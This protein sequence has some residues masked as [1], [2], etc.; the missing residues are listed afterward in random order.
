MFYGGYEVS[1]WLAKVT[2]IYLY[3]VKKIFN[4]VHLYI[5]W[6]KYNKNPAILTPTGGKEALRGYIYFFYSA[7]SIP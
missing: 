4:F 3:K 5:F 1:L 6:L 7:S 2:K